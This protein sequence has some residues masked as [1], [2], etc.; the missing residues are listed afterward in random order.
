MFRE[1]EKGFR[2]VLV[3][4]NVSI[5][6]YDSS[7][8]AQSP[9][10]GKD[11]PFTSKEQDPVVTPE[12]HHNPGGLVESDHLGIVETTRIPDSDLS[13]AHLAE[14]GCCNGIPLAHPND[15]RTLDTTVALGGTHRVSTGTRVEQTNFSIPASCDQDIS[16]GVEGKALDCVAMT[17][18][19]G[20]W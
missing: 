12:G 19:G 11:V 20:F 2:F 8:E 1:G 4:P 15:T 9:T 3:V 18:E 6:V 17:T 13:V 14:T 7:D 16:N 10:Q 5:A